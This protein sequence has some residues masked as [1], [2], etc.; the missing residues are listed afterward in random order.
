MRRLCISA[1]SSIIQSSEAK[2]IPHIAKVAPLMGQLIAQIQRNYKL[3]IALTKCMQLLV[4][5]SV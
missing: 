2:F 4:N 5:C 3:S 1:I